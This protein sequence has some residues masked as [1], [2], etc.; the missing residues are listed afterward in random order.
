[1]RGIEI[2]RKC[3][4]FYSLGDFIFQ[5]DTV[6]HLPAD[7]YEKYGLGHEHNVVDALEKR[8]DG[9]KRGL[10]VNPE[11]WRSV[12]ARWDVE[13]GELTQLELFPIALGFDESP[14]RRGWPHLTKDAAVLEHL[15]DL[16]TP[17]HTEMEI[18]GGVGKV[19]LR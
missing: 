11:V 13:Q 8:S 2:Y 18:S 5:N 16:S 3:P 14:Y 6:A 12:V 10:G 4:I 17:F 7:F 1:L 9:G 15:R 19:L